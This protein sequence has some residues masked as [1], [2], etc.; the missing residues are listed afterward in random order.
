MNHPVPALNA[1]AWLLIAA[2]ALAPASHAG[3]GDKLKKKV[4]DKAAEKVERV[5]PQEEAAEPAG[6]AEAGTAGEGAK[7]SAVSTK[8]DFVPGDRVL[9]ADDFTQDELG[10]FP[11]RWKLIGGTFEVAEREGERWLRCTS[12]D[13]HVRMKLPELA[14]LP[15]LWTLELDF[16]G[17]EPMGSAL[18]V[19]ALG[20]NDSPVWEATFP[21]GNDLAFRTGD[22]FSTTPLE[23]GVVPGRH[24][25]MFMARGTALKAYMDRQR[26]ANVPEISPAAGPPLELEIRLWASTGPMIT[27]VRFAEG[28]RPPKD[29]LAEGTLVTHGIH[30]RSGSDAVLPESAPV[31]RQVAAYLESNPAVTLRITG[32]TDDVGEPAGN[33][34]LS[35]R[36]GASV[37]KVLAEEFG[38]AAD[39]LATDGKGDTE[40]IAANS[41]PEG[42]AMNRRV[43]FTKR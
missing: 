23:S 39:R 33:L 34:D 37:A 42:R 40:A 11:A 41:I 29:L 6:A 14:Q 9:F 18:T 8:F 24:H 10:E 7:V 25:V 20:R 35:R 28:C 30:F 21:Q 38:I 15:E 4:Q 26:M 16:L 32:H 19:R 22:N 36:R 17:E 1:P 2:L 43:E 13:G 5:V 3:L 31:L 27:N 12:V